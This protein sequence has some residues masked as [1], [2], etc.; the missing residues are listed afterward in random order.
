MSLELKKRYKKIVYTL[1]HK[2]AFL[3]VEKQLRGRNTLRGYFHDIDKPFMYM[4]LWIK[5]EDVSKI[6]RQNSYHH[7]ESNLDKT[8]E[9]LIDMI[10]DWECARQTK[11]DKPL[12]AYQ[13]LMRYYPEYQ[14]EFIPLIKELLPEQIKEAKQTTKHKVVKV[15]VSKDNIRKPI[16]ISKSQYVIN[17]SI[18]E[19]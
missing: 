8:R 6:H 15:N 4:A 12:N 3:K 11:P 16:V 7:L 14:K 10:I 19:R 18:I 17:Q 1:K 2:K 5:V 13:T 9:D